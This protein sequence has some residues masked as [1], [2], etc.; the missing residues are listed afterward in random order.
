MRSPR[1]DIEAA[2]TP[3]NPKSG[4]PG[5][6][7]RAAK[8]KRP[9]LSPAAPEFSL[10]IVLLDDDLDAAVLRLAHTVGGRHQ[11]ALLA[12]ADDRDRLRRHALAHQ[13]V[14]DRIGAPP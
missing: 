1:P 13:R 11:Q 12:H 9:G 10:R 2:L 7:V 6:N 5:T 4:P 8:R 3:A 14:L